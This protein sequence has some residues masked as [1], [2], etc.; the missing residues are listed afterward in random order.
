V[1]AALRRAKTKLVVVGPA[2]ML[3]ELAQLLS[4]GW[5]GGG[6]GS[7]ASPLPRGANFEGR[8][9]TSGGGG[10]LCCGI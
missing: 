8:L 1:E 10:E 2:S 6:R 7:K 3:Q 9:G 5:Q 4:R